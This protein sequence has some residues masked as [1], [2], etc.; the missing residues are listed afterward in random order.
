MINDSKVIT[1]IFDGI[2]V[3][4]SP[5]TEINAELS[6]QFW[7][8]S[9]TDNPQI[10]IKPWPNVNH[11]ESKIVPWDLDIH[12]LDSFSYKQSGL[13]PVGI[14]GI[15]DTDD[16]E[17]TTTIQGDIE[18]I[19]RSYPFYVYNR[20]LNDTMSL[21]GIDSNGNGFNPW[22]DRV[23]VG[24]SNSDGLWLGTTCEIDFAGVQEE[25]LPTTGDIYSVRF[26]R[27]FWSGDHLVFDTGDFGSVSDSKLS[28]E[29]DKIKVVP[30]PYVMTN[31]LEESIYNTD[32]N[33]RR[34]L[35]F[36]HFY[37]HNVS[38]KYIQ[39]LVFWLIL[40]K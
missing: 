16:Q 27:P 2:Q 13:I 22:E 33:Q 15:Y 11:R 35:M 18:S 6:E 12:F 28:N 37:L 29:M 39:F 38:L 5:S 36:T 25:S 23:I 4:I 8:Q 17:I 9:N 7:Y 40:L 10:F 30:N 24:S 32:F 34:K 31:L 1:D 26:N 20:T 21:I 14:N 3:S 19:S